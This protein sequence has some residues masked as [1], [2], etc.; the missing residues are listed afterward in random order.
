VIEGEIRET[1]G[2]AHERDLGTETRRERGD[3]RGA[4]A[5]SGRRAAME[6]GTE[7]GMGRGIG[8]SNEIYQ[9]D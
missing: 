4:E 5:L 7:I 2:I 8:I 6:E 9:G 1:I 3:I